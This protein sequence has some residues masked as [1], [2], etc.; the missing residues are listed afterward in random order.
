MRRAR[1]RLDARGRL[2]LS[3]HA[4]RKRRSR[5]PPARLHG[6]DALPERG[7]QLEHLSRRPRQHL[8]LGQ[9]LLLSQAHGHSARR[10]APGKVPRVGS[11]SRRRHRLQHLHQNVSL[12]AGPV[13][14]RRRARHSAGDRSFSQLV[15]LQYLR[16]LGVVALDS[17]AAGH[18][19]RQEAV[20]ENSAGAGNRR[21]VRRRPRQ[22]HPAPARRSQAPHLLAQFFPGLRPHDALVR[23]RAHS[24]AAQAG[25]EARREVD[26]RAAGDDRR[27]RRHLSGHAQR[28]HRAALPR[29]LRRRSAGHSRPRRV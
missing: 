17:R 14:L 7:R 6:D 22:L 18:H 12:R 11:G 24:P 3:A 27:P 13:R 1:S 29:L 9:V 15:L 2:H 28:H 23:S 26:A 25:H 20:Q 5:P 21:A 8:A 10:S 16:N 4:A 19:V